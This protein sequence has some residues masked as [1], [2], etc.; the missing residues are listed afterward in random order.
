MSQLSPS[1]STLHRLA[2]VSADIPATLRRPV[3][4]SQHSSFSM[5]PKP[6]FGFERLEGTVRRAPEERLYIFMQKCGHVI[7]LPGISI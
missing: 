4:T 7:Y 6:V 1:C 5:A 2:L 3:L